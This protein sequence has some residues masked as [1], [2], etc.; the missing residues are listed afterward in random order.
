MM[1]Y[2]KPKY[3]RRHSHNNRHCYLNSV[4]QFILQHTCLLPDS[5]VYICQL[6]ANQFTVWSFIPVSGHRKY[7]RTGNFRRSREA[8]N[9]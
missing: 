9:A 3:A 1:C 4:M 7:N 8:E 5:E 6:L 2:T